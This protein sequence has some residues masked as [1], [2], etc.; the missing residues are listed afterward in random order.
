MRVLKRENRGYEEVNLNKITSRIKH[1]CDDLSP[2]VDPTMI[3]IQTIQKLYDGITTEELDKISAKT[4]E[5]YQL[6]H[7]DYSILAARICVSN[8][9][10]TT[11]KTFT[12]CM[13][14]LY[15]ALSIISDDALAF[16]IDNSAAIDAMIIDSNDY[17]YDFLGFKTMERSYL[18]KIGEIVCD[19]PQ[20][21]YMRVA[22]MLNLYEKVDIETKLLSIK[23]CYEALSEMYFTHATPTLFNSC[24]NNP[25]LNSCFLL[26]TQDS[27]EGIMKNLCDCSFISKRAGGI[28]V[29]MSNI[30]SARSYIKGTNGRSKGLVKQLKMYN[31]A[32]DCWDQGGDKRKGAFAI[33][34]ELH[35]GDIKEFLELKL[36]TGAETERARDLFY[37][38][39]VSD[40][41]IKRVVVDNDWSLFSE[42]TAPGLSDVYDGME[43]CTKCNGTNQEFPPKIRIFTNPDPKSFETTT[44]KLDRNCEHQFEIKNLF[45]ELYET[46]EKHGLAM[47]KIK[48]RILLDK[49]LAAQRESDRKS[50]V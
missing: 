34:L 23:T 44:L 26:G 49:I 30:R 31:A 16:I 1:L 20:Y 28:G 37:A 15:N 50:V 41:F 25:Q 47:E 35:H 48:P 24:T 32:A 4:A 10:K 6:V 45:T 29:H 19:R 8:L 21:M 39:W 12:A 38:I 36:N 17:Q 43:V 33:Y 14:E 3:S 40:L 7:P 27:I 13:V 2:V 18:I 22:I 11:P 42:D 5:S 9:H 46:Y